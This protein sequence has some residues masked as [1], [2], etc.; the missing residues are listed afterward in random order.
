MRGSRDVASWFE[1]AH[2]TGTG[3]RLEAHALAL[4]LAVTRR[5]WGSF[6]A[7]NLSASALISADV[8]RVLPDRL[9]NIVIE[10]TGHGLRADEA[11]LRQV[12]TDLRARGARLAVD[13]AGSDYAGLRELLMVAPDIVKLD[14]DLVH[15]VRLDPVKTALVGAL[16]AYARE[17]GVMLCAEGVED[18]DD[19]ER[20]ADLDVAYAQGY[21]SGRPARPWVGVAPEAA[22]VCAG[23]LA[24]TLTGATTPDALAGDGRLQWLTWKLS[25]ATDFAGLREAVDCIQEELGSDELSISVVEG[26]DLISVGRAGP[27]RGQ[28]RYR[29]ADYPETARLLREQDSVQ[30]SMNDPEADPAELEVLR[31]YG[32]RSVLMLPVCC[33][34]RAIGLF[35]AFSATGRPFSRYEIGRARIIALHL[36]ATLERINRN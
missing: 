2:R 25:E 12:R 34:G 8:A 14:R 16:V 23:S 10:L 1:Q 17:L 4:A 11:V 7:V 30:V 29:I 31:G 32:Y 19:L 5:P 28:K 33:A 6:L 15:R 35:E 9:D 18:L 36:G 13:L 20:L 26:E 27:D 22:R 3:P 24:A 21:A